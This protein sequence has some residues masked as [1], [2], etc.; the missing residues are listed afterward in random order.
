MAN[1]TKPIDAFI[2]RVLDATVLTPVWN[3]TQPFANS[4]FVYSYG[5]NSFSI[6]HIICIIFKYHYLQIDLNEGL[7]LMLY[8]GWITEPN[9]N[10]TNSSD[11][12]NETTTDFSTTTESN[13]NISEVVKL[14]KEAR[15][16]TKT[17]TREFF[18]DSCIVLYLP[19]LHRFV[20]FL[21]YWKTFS[22]DNLFDDYCIIPR[23]DAESVNLTENPNLGDPNICTISYSAA[24]A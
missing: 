2:P 11:I 1:L 3:R 10:L 15:Y 17:T 19:V 7:S 23:F 24:I 8:E 20:I 5:V 14:K 9:T 21:K 22:V 6:I 12:A 13:V 18:V 4:M 16:V